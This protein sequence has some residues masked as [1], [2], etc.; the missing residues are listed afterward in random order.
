M[1]KK[2]EEEL[3]RMISKGEKDDTGTYEWNTRNKGKASSVRE[4]I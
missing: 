4:S 3:K 2:A 1:N